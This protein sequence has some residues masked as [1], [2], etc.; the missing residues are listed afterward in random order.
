MEDGAKDIMQQFLYEED[1]EDEVEPLDDL[2]DLRIYVAS[3]IE[4]SDNQSK[5]FA[6]V[7]PIQND[8]DFGIFPEIPPSRSNKSSFSS[9]Q[10]SP[11]RNVSSYMQLQERIETVENVL[12]QRIEQLEEMYFHLLAKVDKINNYSS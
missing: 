9:S 11:N 1:S 10:P 4:D 6:Q 12:L 3:L 2:H 7:P 5:V 8:R